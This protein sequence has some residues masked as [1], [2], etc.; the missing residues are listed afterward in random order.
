VDVLSKNNTIKAASDFFLS[1]FPI[2]VEP[3]LA[4]TSAR[5]TLLYQGH[6]SFYHV[7]LCNQDISQL[8]TAAISP[9][10]VLNRVPHYMQKPGGCLAKIFQMSHIGTL[11]MAWTTLQRSQ[12]H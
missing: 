4:D 9:K 5:R 1:N 3:L 11:E 6:Q 2:T 10:G 8:R 12:P 7:D